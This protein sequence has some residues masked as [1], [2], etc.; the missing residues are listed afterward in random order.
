MAPVASSSRFEPSTLIF[1]VRGRG[2]VH[3]PA[4]HKA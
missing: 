3:D 2:G 4:V 1:R